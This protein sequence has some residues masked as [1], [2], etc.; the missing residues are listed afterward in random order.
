MRKRFL[1]F[2]F[3]VSLWLAFGVPALADDGAL[4]LSPNDFESFDDAEVRA[5][6]L[7]FYDPL[8]SGNRNI[9]CATC[10][11]PRFATSDGLSLGLGEGGIGL[12]PDRHA[13]ADNLP[14]QRVPRNSPA[15]F[16][17]GHRDILVMFHDGRI[18]RDTRRASGFRTPLE[19][20]MV[21]GFSGILSAQ[22]MFPVLS[23]DEMAGHYQENDVSKAVRQGRLTGDG[24]AWD[25][26]AKRVDAIPAYRDA[27]EA[28]DPDITAGDAIAFT[29]ISNVIAA[30]IATEWRAD[31][32][33]YDI[34]LRGGPALSPEAAKGMELF[35]G[36]G[37]CA[38]CHSGALLSDQAFHAMADPQLGP[39]KAAR[40]ETHQRDTGRMR[41]TGAAEDA[42]AFRT[43]MLRN[44]ARTGPWGHAGAHSDLAHF[45]RYH[46]DP[47][48]GLAVY[49]P[50]AELS[51]LP[52]AADDWAVMQDQNERAAIAAA[53][54][55]QAVS[56]SDEDIA[57]LTA[58]LE[59]L[60]DEASLSGR[61]GIPDAVPSRLPID[62]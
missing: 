45:L 59:A 22:T 10:H 47:L 15:L 42:Y 49:T 44:V 43:P 51:E 31:Q 35:F 7:L 53:F 57:A 39:G 12:G 19:E 50:E 54:G 46:A 61:R 60:T 30:F 56:L 36:D 17:L 18:E 23:A 1:S 48:A 24:G 28:F 14:E 16:N 13:D 40:F 9:S 55:G 33:P 41:V 6:W 25:I 11:H 52:N 37:G 62:R 5:G 34:M 58:F 3:P 27:F 8:L 38:G 4:A 21:V 32:T 29:D 26:I 2:I 20:E